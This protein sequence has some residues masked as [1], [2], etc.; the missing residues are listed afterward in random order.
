MALNGCVATPVH[1]WQDLDLFFKN[2]I[3]IPPYGTGTRYWYVILIV[4]LMQLVNYEMWSLI[5]IQSKSS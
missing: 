3:W 2:G 4:T 1:F 5:I